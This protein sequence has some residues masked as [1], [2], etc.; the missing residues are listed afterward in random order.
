M[1][2]Y[3]SHVISPQECVFQDLGQGILENALQVS[4]IS[5]SNQIH[6]MYTHDTLMR[7]QGYNATLLAYGQTGSGKSYSMVG[8]RPNKGL[9]PKLCERLFEAIKENQDTRQCQVNKYTAVR[10]Y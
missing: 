3:F 2:E 10:T 9:V 1:N 4:N 5:F 8:Y 6:V 7:V